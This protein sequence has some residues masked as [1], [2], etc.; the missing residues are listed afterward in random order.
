MVIE[1]IY[2][3]NR[4]FYIFGVLPDNHVILNHLSI[5]RVHAAIVISDEVQII[6]LNSKAGTFVNTEKLNSLV[7]KS[8]VIGDEISFGASSRTYKI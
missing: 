5:S 4:P 8:T 3:E 1:T 6:D 7:P 2:L